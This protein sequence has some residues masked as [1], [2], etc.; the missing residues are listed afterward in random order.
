MVATATE[1]READRIVSPEDGA[2]MV[3]FLQAGELTG[4]LEYEDFGPVADRLCPDG[5]ETCGQ[6]AA[7]LADPACHV[8][9]GLLETALRAVAPGKPEHDLPPQ[10]WAATVLEEFLRLRTT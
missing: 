1:P 2:A 3:A 5:I 10:P 7:V 9:P 8:K 4:I 6:L